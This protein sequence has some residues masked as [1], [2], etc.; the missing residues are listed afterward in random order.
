MAVSD[1]SR[2]WLVVVGLGVVALAAAAALAPRLWAA[3]RPVRLG[4]APNWLGG[5]SG[6]AARAPATPAAPTREASPECGSEMLLVDGIYCPYVGHRCV[7]WIEESRDRCRRYDE[8]ILCEGTKVSKRF[9][10]DR[11]EYPNQ[12]GAYP[13]VMTSWVEAEQACLAEGKRLCTEDEW[14]F[15]CEGETRVPYPY[16]F[17]RKSDACNIDR[18][19]RDPD[20]S[21][22]SHDRLI[23]EEVSRLDQR[24]PSGS[25]AGCVSPFGVHDMTGNVD[26]WVLNE[27]PKTD[28]GEDVSSL[29]GGYWGP[30][31][32][33]CRPVTSSHNRW[34]RF[35][36]V[37]FRCCR[38]VKG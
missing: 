9:C 29:K 13:A 22:F 38:D 18:T 8:K 23:S 10:I 6:H 5:A 28:K 11:Y 33:R 19:Y 7:E 37:G 21:A 12:A 17:E 35:Y 2:T 27:A 20:F 14:T 25:M 26:E 15:A 36:Q 24:V 16:G 32:A 1:A 34:F 31:R 30:I 3:P 4:H